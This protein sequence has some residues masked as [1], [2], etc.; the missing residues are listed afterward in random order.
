MPEASRQE[1]L[2]HDCLSAP[3]L[4]GV[5]GGKGR[6]RMLSEHGLQALVRDG[7]IPRPFMLGKFR[8]WRWGAV[9]AAIQKLESKA[10][11]AD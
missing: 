7:V 2:D 3:Q 5:L 1:F 4:R 9:K 10:A 6:G 11:H 8:R